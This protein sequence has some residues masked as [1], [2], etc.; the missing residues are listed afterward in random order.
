M[1]THKRTPL[2]VVGSPLSSAVCTIT[3]VAVYRPAVGQPAAGNLGG[4]H[5]LGEPRR[6]RPPRPSRFFLP[7]EASALTS[8][9]AK[10]QIWRAYVHHRTPGR[11]G[12]TETHIFVG[13]LAILTT[14]CGEQG[15]RHHPSRKPPTH[16]IRG[17]RAARLQSA[18]PSLG[19]QCAKRAVGE[20]RVWQLCVA[21]AGTPRCHRDRGATVITAPTHDLTH[22]EHNSRQF[23][24][25]KNCRAT[26]FG[27]ATFS[28][29]S[30]L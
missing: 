12:A 20:Q 5:P 23:S 27:R 30:A 29:A 13:F 2:S 6:R 7:I 10:S 8:P 3:T 9:R 17:A 18:H 11:I 4:H 15:S 26:G 28:P 14:S 1:R 19:P 21:G 25:A 24:A 22:L 16:A